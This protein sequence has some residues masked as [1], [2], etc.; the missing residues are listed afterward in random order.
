VPLEINF[1]PQGDGGL[2]GDLIIHEPG[3][4]VT[5]LEGRLDGNQVEFRSPI[6]RD[7]YVFQGWREGDRLSGTYRVSP[8]GGEGRWSVKIVGGEP[9]S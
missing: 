6:G 4:G 7:L 1:R 8:S 2:R 9:S 3:Y 5:Q